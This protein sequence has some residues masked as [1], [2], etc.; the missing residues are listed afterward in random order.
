MNSVTKNWVQM[1]I[2]FEFDCIFFL[3]CCSVKNA[4]DRLGQQS[5]KHI[6]LAPYELCK[7]VVHLEKFFQDVVDKGGEGIILRDP[8]SPYQ[9]GRSAGY[10]KHK[11]TL[12]DSLLFYSNLN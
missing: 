8:L 2:L 10:L 9:E 5:W 4:V 3:L 12:R 1:Q 7:D 6:E 11:V